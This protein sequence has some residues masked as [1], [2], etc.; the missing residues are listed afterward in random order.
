[1]HIREDRICIYVQPKPDR[2][3]QKY[4]TCK[5]AKNTGLQTFVV[6]AE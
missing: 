4:Q 1:M 3:L 6:N 2:N 5:P